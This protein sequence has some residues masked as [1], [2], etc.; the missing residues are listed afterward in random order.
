[1][2]VGRADHAG[3]IGDRSCNSRR[4]WCRGASKSQRH[5]DRLGSF[6]GKSAAIFEPA[7]HAQSSSN[8]LEMERIV[9]PFRHSFGDS[10]TGT[11]K[12]LRFAENVLSFS[13]YGYSKEK[14]IL[15][16]SSGSSDRGAGRSP[17]AA[18][19]L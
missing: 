1:G 19:F 18:L 11:R 10:K 5:L 4:G 8:A 13:L 12:L 2:R 7:V 6:D 9:A 3:P 16:S 14:C 17:F 15:P